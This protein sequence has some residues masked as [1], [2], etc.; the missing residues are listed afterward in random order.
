M[1]A[2]GANS[3]DAGAVT[4]PQFNNNLLTISSDV[5]LEVREVSLESSTWSFDSDGPRGTGHGDV[6]RDSNEL[7]S[8]DLLH[9]HTTRGTKMAGRDL[10]KV[11]SVSR[12]KNSELPPR[13]SI[14]SRDQIRTTFPI[15]SLQTGSAY[16]RSGAF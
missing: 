14:L 5:D 13:P 15:V 10:E 6:S 16:G 11:P 12:E 1:G 4:E 2:D 7:G 9:V 8:L 3:G